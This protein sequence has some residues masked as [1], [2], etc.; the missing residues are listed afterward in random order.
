MDHHNTGYDNLKSFDVAFCDREDGELFLV[1]S[2]EEIFDGLIP[3]RKPS[4]FSMQGGL[5]QVS[6]SLVT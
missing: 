6:N 3:D 2:E 5:P 4:G 1:P